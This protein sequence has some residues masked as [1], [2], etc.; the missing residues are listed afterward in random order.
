MGIRFRKSK[1]IAPGVR[2]NVGK[3]SASVSLGGK[4]FRKTYSSSGR[5]TT[6]VGMPVTGI[7]YVSSTGN[8]KN[9]TNKKKS[10]MT[11]GIETFQQ[12]N[13]ETPGWYRFSKYAGYIAGGLICPTSLILCLISIPFGLIML[14]FGIFLIYY[15]KKASRKLQEQK[16][17]LNS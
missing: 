12:I 6:S 8:N 14:A 4:G 5:K 3:K 2:L 10:N 9:E 1:K 11:E 15:G 7:S 17:K 13:Y 16:E